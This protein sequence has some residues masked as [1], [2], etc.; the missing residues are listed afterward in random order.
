MNTIQ[1]GHLVLFRDYL[2]IFIQYALL[3]RSS[4]DLGRLTAALFLNP[5]QCF[6]IDGTHFDNF[7]E[8]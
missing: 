7:P 6:R 1:W 4:L 3:G 5:R 2:F 8:A